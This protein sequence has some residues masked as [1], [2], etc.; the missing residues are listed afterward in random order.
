MWFHYS[1]IENI[2]QILKNFLSSLVPKNVTTT[3]PLRLAD[4]HCGLSLVFY[5]DS[6]K[7]QVGSANEILTFFRQE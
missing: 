5:Y 2:V 4:V 6:Q 7:F 3:A 1:H